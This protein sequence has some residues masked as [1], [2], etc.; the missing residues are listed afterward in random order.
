MSIISCKDCKPPKRYPGCHDHCPEYLAEKAEHDKCKAEEYK[1]R[2]TS[3]GLTIERTAAVAKAMRGR[4]SC[5]R[6]IN[7]KR[8]RE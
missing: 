7:P 1:K 5:Y 4:R 6:S 3:Y 8:G 2:Q